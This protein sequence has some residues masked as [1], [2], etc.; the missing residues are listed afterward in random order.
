[1]ADGTQIKITAVDATTAAF[2]SVQGNISSLSN[3]LRSIA[4]PLAAAFSVASV[5][6]FTKQMIDVAGR[7]DDV[8]QQTGIAASRL[9]ALGNAALLN[10][11]SADQMNSAL[12]KLN[13]S[14]SEAAGGSKQQQEA[15]KAL[16]ISMGD[17]EKMS[18]EEVLYA[19]A[20]AFA[21]A[22]DGANKTAIAVALLGKSGAEL[23][24]T[25]NQGSAALKG[26]NSSFTDEQIKLLAQTGDNIDKISISLQKLAAAP[27]AKISGFL[28]DLFNRFSVLDDLAKEQGKSFW[29]KLFTFPKDEINARLAEVNKQ[30]D[31]S[32][33][34]EF[35][36]KVMGQGQK[37][38]LKP[39]NTETVKELKIGSETLKAYNDQLKRLDDI[40]K[41]IET[42]AQKYYRQLQELEQIQHLLFPDE[43]LDRIMAINEEFANSQPQI[44]R[45]KTAL[46]EYAE[47]AK[48]VGQSLDQVAVRAMMNLEDSLVGVM[49]G[50]M[51]VKEAFSNMAMSIIQDLIRIHIQKSITGPIAE[52]ISSS[53]FM[54]SIGNIFGGA[55]ALGGTVQANKAYLVGEKGPELFVPGKTGGIAP[56][57][58]GSGATVVI[59]NYSNASATA[60]ETTDGRGNR[61]I[62]VTIGEIVSGEVRRS[63][64]ALNNAFRE[65]FNTSPMLVGR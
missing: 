32:K 63:G 38:D 8:S 4:G 9:S 23:I 55:R 26:F 11:A 65:S 30:L 42:P 10:G 5:A 24:P 62:D 19:I 21:G 27:V 45:N 60:T 12:V 46:E 52:A 40:L 17:I 2:R 3:S 54:Q 57:G 16:G 48:K 56:N 34:D 43:V 47:S 31:E 22:N 39:I 20:D 64:S 49:T 18:P 33:A 61:R 28:N 37:K 13:R 35:W 51:S 44:V 1:M 59:N 15:F 14:I 29:L 7:L 25:L 36:K 53:G 41:G 50:T 6:A 58:A